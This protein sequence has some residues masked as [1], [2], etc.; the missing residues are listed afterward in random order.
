MTDANTKGTTA[1]RIRLVL[2]TGMSGAGR[3]SA[4][5]ALEDA[6]YEAIDNLPLALLGSLVRGEALPGPG[7][8]IDV[9]I[10]TRDF[11]VDRF[12]ATVDPLF[13]LPDVAGKLLFIDCDDEV[14]RRRH[15]E[16]R[17][18]HPLARDRPVVDGIRLERRLIEGLRARADVVI[19]TTDLNVGDLR[20]LVVGHFALEGRGGLAVF[21]TSF[22]YRAGLPREADLVFDVRFLANPHYREDLRPRSGA[23]PEVAAFI[24]ADPAFAPF[25]AQVE[26]LIGPLLPRF[27]REGKSYLTIAI[28]CTGGRH[29]SVLV[30][31]RLA[32]LL[33]RKGYMVEVAHRD[34]D[35]PLPPTADPPQQPSTAP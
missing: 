14:L 4:L 23:D 17:R 8:A 19:D 6:G 33:R 22:A 3:S 27:E 20:R 35:V 1:A 18:R 15:T 25:L 16:T 30:A 2:V 26:G 24:A 21:V 5:A 34:L 29:R 28:G 32:P 9:D 11:S 12:T 13:A 10:R 31:E 7:I